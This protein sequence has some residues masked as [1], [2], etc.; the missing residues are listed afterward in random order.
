MTATP[1]RPMTAPTTW[2]HASAM[3]SV[4]ELL[5][6]LSFCATVAF[7]GYA[8]ATG[9]MQVLSQGAAIVFI[10]TLVVVLVHWF[11]AVEASEH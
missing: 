3:W 4:V 7:G 6:G 11:R 1:T 10:T 9:H 5:L 8:A 2:H